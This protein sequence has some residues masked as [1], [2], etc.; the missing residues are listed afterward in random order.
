MPCT[1]REPNGIAYDGTEA[2]RFALELTAVPQYVLCVN[3]PAP[4][5]LREPSCTPSSA[6]AAR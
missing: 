2:C 6:P 1:E 3:R 4:C 5:T